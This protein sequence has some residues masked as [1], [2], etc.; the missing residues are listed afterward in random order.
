VTNRKL[1]GHLTI[2]L[3]TQTHTLHRRKASPWHPDNYV[4]LAGWARGDEAPQ[5]RFYKQREDGLLAE[6]LAT[7]PAFLFGL[8]V[9]FDLLQMFADQ[10]K[11]YKAWQEW[12]AA[13][14]MIFDCQLAEYL[15]EAMTQQNHMLSMDEIAPRYG[16]TLKVDAVKELWAAGV[17]TSDIDPDLLLEYL[18]G[19]PS[20]GDLGDIGNTRHIALAQIARAKA[21]GQVNSLLLNMGSL[22]AS[23]EMEL[24]GMKVDL[25]RGLAIAETLKAEVEKV[26][27]ALTEYLPKDLPF[28]FKWT[29]RFHKAALIFGGEVQ[30]DDVEYVHEDGTGTLCSVWHDLR[31]PKTYVQKE[32]EE[33]VLDAEG[34]PTFYKS[35]KNLGMPKTRKVKVPDL[36]R[37]KTRKCRAPYTFKGYTEP[38]PEWAGA[39]GVYSTASEIIEEL[40]VRGIPFLTALARLQS[41]TKD[42]GTYYVVT[43]PKTGD[44]KGML[45]LVGL[46][47]IVHHG[48]NHCSTVTG[49]FSSANPNLQNVPKGSKSDVKTVFISRYAGGSILQSDFSALEVYV[50]AFLTNCQQLIADLRAGL[51]MHCAR[52]AAKEHLP[53]DEVYA[54]CKGDKYDKA[55]D[56]KRT[57][58]KVFS[59]QRTYGAG[60]PKIAASTG[61]SVEEVEALIEA[62]ERMYPEITEHFERLTEEVKKNRKPTGT[63]VPHPFIPGV[64]CSLGKSTTRT[65]DGC[66]Y[67]YVESPSPAYLCKR[68]I[69]SSFSP[70]VIKN[71]STQG[72]GAT[73]MKAAMYLAVRA[74]YTT[75]NLNGRAVLVNTVHDAQYV[76]AAPEALDAAYSILHESMAQATDLMRR[77][78]KWD[79]PL[80]VP[81]DTVRGSSMA[82]EEKFTPD[83]QA[84][85]AAKELVK[86]IKLAFTRTK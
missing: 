48:I 19:N 72:T 55:W 36:D 74:F 66:V 54:L 76:D 29:S 26:T 62:E 42:L 10:P 56:Y 73:V 79:I 64:M 8:N 51:D 71:Y 27:Q 47:G 37:P 86:S 41:I 43:D 15:L 70:T 68:G 84:A 46:D 85:N 83:P 49:R 75:G 31:Q 82:E 40:G 23:T 2:D 5:H 63:T 38:K 13:G 6:L 39:D 65:P 50:Q 67:G 77:L 9:K 78:F 81:S 45:S 32:I 24:N 34:N 3:E 59:F 44:K 69:T 60:A 11:N 35:G 1:S 53:Y 7:N 30:Y 21:N 20:T 58:A 12:V 18:C 33:P 17:Q 52:L 4:V 16:G 28:E 57:N 25:D 22:I 80:D 61:M 14:G